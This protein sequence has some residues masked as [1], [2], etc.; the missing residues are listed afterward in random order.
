MALS[1][2]STCSQ[3]SGLV[4]HA[5]L[6][7]PQS[8]KTQAPMSAVPVKADTAFQG[9]AL[10]SVGRQTRS[11]AA[12]N[13]A[14]KDLVASRD[15]EVGSSVS[16]L[17]SEG[18]EDL[19]SIATTSSDLSEVVDVVEED[20]GGANIRVRKASGK[21]GTRTS[22]RRALVM[23]LALGMVR[24]I[25]GN[26]TGG[27]QAGNLRRTTSTNLRRSASSSFTVSGNLQSQVSI[28]SSLKAA[29]LLDD[30][31]KNNVPTL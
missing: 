4:V 14:L 23:C 16:K 10:R 25:S 13:V 2:S 29:N 1:Q 28:A 26:A 8:P 19:D 31:L 20:A 11:M 17:V 5:D 7:R 3:V 21:A 12:P 9:T 24:P 22:R 27:L 15:A 18:S 6:A 30:K